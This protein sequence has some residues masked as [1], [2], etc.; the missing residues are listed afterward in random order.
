MANKK[1][2]MSDSYVY[3]YGEAGKENYYLSTVLFNDNKTEPKIDSNIKGYWLIIVSLP[4]Y[5]PTTGEIGKADMFYS[6]MVLLVE[7]NRRNE[8]GFNKAVEMMKEASEKSMEIMEEDRKYIKDLAKWNGISEEAMRERV[9]KKKEEIMNKMKEDEEMKNK[10]NKKK[11]ITFD[12]IAGCEDAKAI[13]LDVIDQ[14]KNSEKYE[15]FDIDPIKS[16]LLW[17]APGTGKTYIANAF[18]NMLDANFVKINMGDVASKYQ[19]QTGNNIKKIF[20][21][22]RE[23]EQFTVLFWDEIDAVANRRGAEEN[24]KE[25]NA[26]LRSEEHT[27]ELQSR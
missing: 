20:D 26:T 6:D 10:K 11:K 5:N 22:A 19:G 27:S 17:G 8:K 21:E 15:Y 13:F 7:C 16:L 3:K 2:D 14:L 24:S 18:S 12:D 25:K 4:N 23:A 9:E 1:W